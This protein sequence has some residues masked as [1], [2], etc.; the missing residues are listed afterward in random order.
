[1]NA[2]TKQPRRFAYGGPHR[3]HVTKA[4]R[5]PNPPLREDHAAVVEGRTRYPKS[6]KFAE[7]EA[8]ILKGGWNQ[9]KL[10]GKVLKGRWKGMPIFA[11][12]LEERATCPRTCEMYR[13]CYG[14]GMNWAHRFVHDRDL[15]DLLWLELTSY[16]ESH[17]D[18][19]VIRLHVLGDFY[20]VEYV[21]L[22][23][24]ALIVFPALRVFGFTARR[25]EDPIGREL[26]RTSRE[27]PDRFVMRW[28]GEEGPRGAVTIEKGEA[29]RHT[30]CPAQQRD[31]RFCGNCAFCWH[32]DATVAFWRH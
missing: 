11:L 3:R 14:N 19:F 29:T 9:E 28:S 30:V 20:S 5:R 2:P 31:D 7:E 24:R 6:R 8:R 18:G 1:M 13:A 12:T 27:F 23:I 21:Q 10:G 26:R 32:S 17:P 16:A 4:R 15:E 25:P 22:W